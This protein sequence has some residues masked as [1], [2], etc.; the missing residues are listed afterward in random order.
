MSES[1][2]NNEDNREKLSRDCVQHWSVD[3]LVEYAIFKLDK[4]YK[5][6]QDSFQED[7]KDVYGVDE[8]DRKIFFKENP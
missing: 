4:E 3:D 2:P 7:W 5:D 6:D 8:G 1:V